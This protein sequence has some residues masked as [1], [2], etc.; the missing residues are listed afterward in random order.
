ME[1]VSKKIGF[2][3]DGK[4]SEDGQKLYAEKLANSTEKWKTIPNEILKQCREKATEDGGAVVDAKCSMVP[5]KFL[6]CMASQLFLVTLKFYSL[7]NIFNTYFLYIYRIVPQQPGP[8][9]PNATN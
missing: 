9:T 8:M 5:F 7:K 3:K 4:L 6:D 2:F 1:C